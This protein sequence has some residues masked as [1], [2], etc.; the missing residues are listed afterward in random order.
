MKVKVSDL[1]GVALDFAVGIAT[2]QKM[3]FVSIE[4]PK[5]VA[6]GPDWI[7][8][9]EPSTDWSC[10]G[11]L[12]EQFQ[13]TVSSPKSPVHRNGGPLSGWGESGAWTAC[14]WDKGLNGKRSIVWSEE[15]PLVA[16][17]RAIVKFK[18]GDEIDIP[19]ELIKTSPN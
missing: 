12:I 19:D 4:H 17:C 11:P 2:G 13:L 14:T 18:L 8:S 6:K 10:C 15:G 3:Q 7:G 9:F 16:I 1:I 5:S